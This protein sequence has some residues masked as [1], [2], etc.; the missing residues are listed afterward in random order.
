MKNNFDN[1]LNEQDGDKVLDQYLKNKKKVSSPEKE[2]PTTEDTGEQALEKFF[3]NKNKTKPTSTEEGNSKPKKE[4]V[5]H[6]PKQKVKPKQQPAEPAVEEKVEPSQPVTEEPKKEEPKKEEPKKEEKP[7]KEPEVIKTDSGNVIN[8]HEVPPVQ[9]DIDGDVGAEEET[10]STETTE[11]TQESPKQ[12]PVKPQTTTAPKNPPKQKVRKATVKTNPSGSDKVVHK[13]DVLMEIFQKITFNHDY[14]KLLK[15]CIG[16]S[17]VAFAVLIAFSI[18]SNDSVVKKSDDKGFVDKMVDLNVNGIVSPQHKQNDIHKEEN[19]LL[20][21]KAVNE[22]KA[23]N[24]YVLLEQYN[25]FI[26]KASYKSSENM[27]LIEK[28]MFDVSPEDTKSYEINGRPYSANAV[29]SA[30]SIETPNSQVKQKV[31]SS[32]AQINIAIETAFFNK[33]KATFK[34]TQANEEIVS[35]AVER[36]VGEKLNVKR[37]LIEGDF[38]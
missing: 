28:L 22:G 34:D 13:F 11:P 27:V 3:A 25:E 8:A 10:S 30:W 18:M 37:V 16:V 24:Y 14:S 23:A 1:I 35:F 17:A 19:L 5:K 4:T 26:K 36:V 29:I 12:K 38:K 32:L 21:E 15:V 6:T 20:M 2:I 9:L 33:D 31:E 7:F